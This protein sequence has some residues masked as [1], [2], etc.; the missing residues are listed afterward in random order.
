MFGG[1]LQPDVAVDARA[2]PGGVAAVAQGAAAASPA[3]LTHVDGEGKLRMVDV[4][5]KPHTLV[6]VFALAQR[7]CAPYP[8]LQ[9]TASA[10]ARV[11]LGREAFQQ[12]AENRLKKARVPARRR[13]AQ[14]P[15]WLPGARA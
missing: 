3:A 2:A 1:V 13:C 14:R 9:R 6:R 7:A 15:C 12:V 5:S 10:S 8:W 11:L 4:G